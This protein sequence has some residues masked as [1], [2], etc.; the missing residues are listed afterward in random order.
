MYSVFIVE[1]VHCID[2]DIGSNV[3]A[4]CVDERSARKYIKTLKADFAK[5]AGREW[6]DDY[7][8]EGRLVIREHYLHT[9]GERP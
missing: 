7:Y 5:R 8:Y 3:E 6:N 1:R 2:F 9:K 4:V